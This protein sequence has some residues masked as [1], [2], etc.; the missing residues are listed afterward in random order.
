MLRP[1]FRRDRRGRAGGPV[2]GPPRGARR[3]GRASGARALGRRRRR[4]RSRVARRR[5]GGGGGGCCCRWAARRL[6]RRSG[7][8]DGDCVLVAFA[9]SPDPSSSHHDAADPPRDPISSRAFPAPRRRPPSCRASADPSIQP[10]V[11][12]TT[13]AAGPPPGAERPP[14]GG[15]GDGDGSGG[16]KHPCGPPA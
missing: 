7:D 16:V 6:G 4:R 10:A 1:A 11:A 3:R 13:T 15:E 8:G 5:C 12:A 9:R 2:G 14:L